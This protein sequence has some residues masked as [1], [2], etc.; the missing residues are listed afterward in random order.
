MLHDV[1]LKNKQLKVNNITLEAALDEVRKWKTSYEQAAQIVTPKEELE[2]DTNVVEETFG[3]GSK[4]KFGKTCF[5]DC[6]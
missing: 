2:A 4:G 5:R 6:G 3:Q 1:E